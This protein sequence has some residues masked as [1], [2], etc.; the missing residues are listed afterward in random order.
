MKS[1]NSGWTST[2]SRSTGGDTA[3]DTFALGELLASHEEEE[4]LHG[5][6]VTF[7]N[8]LIIADKSFNQVLF[9]IEL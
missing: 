1:D 9:A 2:L 7:A 4:T 8:Y 6:Q 3:S 5:F